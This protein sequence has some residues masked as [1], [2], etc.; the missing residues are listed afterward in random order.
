MMAGETL[1]TVE[2]RFVT[3]EDPAQLADRVRESVA[4]VVGKHALEEFR[5]KTLPLDD[6]KGEKGGLRPVE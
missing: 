5:V 3:G 6:P 2:L 4:A 1:V